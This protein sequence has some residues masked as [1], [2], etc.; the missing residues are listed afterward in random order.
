MSLESA[1]FDALQA[2]VEGRVY[3][4]VA[5]ENTPRPYFT[6]QQVGGRAVNFVDSALPSKKN[7][8]VQV[9]VWAETRLQ[10]SALGRQAEDTLRVIPALQ[11]TALSALVAVYEPETQLRGTRQDF[12]VW[13]DG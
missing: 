4:D 2:L 3:P 7:A 8:R 1:M 12:S 11:T 10:A 6:Y 9:N 13:F 5:P